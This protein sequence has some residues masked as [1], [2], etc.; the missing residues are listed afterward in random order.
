MRARICCSVVR[1][2]GKQSNVFTHCD[3]MDARLG[4]QVEV[5]VLS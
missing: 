1:L 4:V 3:L 5:E 2:V